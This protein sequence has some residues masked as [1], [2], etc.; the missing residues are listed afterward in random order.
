MR[1]DQGGAALQQAVPVLG[2]LEKLE[3]KGV[4]DAGGTMEL[5]AQSRGADP[6]LLGASAKVLEAAAARALAILERGKAL[7]GPATPR[8]TALFKSL[9]LQVQ[10]QTLEASAKL[11]GSVLGLLLVPYLAAVGPEVE[12]EVPIPAEP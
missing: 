9:K 8:I 5:N 3:L 12:E 11:E 7:L 4:E 6:V 2:P 10:G 1:D